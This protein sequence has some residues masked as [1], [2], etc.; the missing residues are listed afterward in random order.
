MI[1][2]PDNTIVAISTPP[3]SGA[4]GIIRLSGPEALPIAAQF[5]ARRDRKELKDMKPFHL[6]RSL[7]EKDG[8]LIDDVLAVLMKAPHS[9]TGEDMVEIH[10][11][12]GR[13]I[14]EEIVRLAVAIG[15]EPAPPGEFTRRAFLN[16]KLDLT[17]AESVAWLI[18]SKSIQEIKSAAAQMN[19][20][21]KADLQAVRAGLLEAL[22]LLEVHLDFDEYE[23]ESPPVEKVLRLLKVSLAKIRVIEREAE[24]GNLQKDGIK[25]VI[26]GK[27]NVGKSS[28]LNRFLAQRRAIV[29]PEPGTTR[30]TIEEAIIIEGIPF[31][32]IDTAGIRGPRGEI[33]KEGV[34]RAKEKIREADLVLLVMDRATELSEED[35]IISKLLEDKEA[36]IVINKSDLP[37]VIDCP[38]IF[39]EFKHRRVVEISAR[40]RW[41]LEKLE[42]EILKAI[43]HDRGRDEEGGI[44]I[45]TGRFSRLKEVR[46][47]LEKAIENIKDGSPAEVVALDLHQSLKQVKLIL[48]EEYDDDL[49]KEI[50]ANFCVGK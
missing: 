29:S 50:F 15:A 39:R 16:G 41:G 37:D 44:F 24:V 19:G 9:Y 40:K 49:L 1:K 42:E 28:L 3:G 4:I 45:S 43:R 23:G 48:G 38:R 6:Y 46:E 27:P 12:G 34:E 25:L 11:H 35:R 20:D 22:A 13:S 30:D 10:C 47:F 8:F 21:L 26:V 31:R 14:L 5:C 2:A 7:I 33:E 18:E 36:L 17:Q 32:I